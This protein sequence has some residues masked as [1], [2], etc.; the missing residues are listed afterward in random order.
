MTD[1]DRSCPLTTGAL[2]VRSSPEADVAAVEQDRR[3]EYDHLVP[4]F[5]ELARLPPEHAR[6]SLLRAALINGYR[7]VAKHIAGSFHRRGD[8]PEDIE[9]VATLGLILAVDRFDATRGADFLSFAVPTIT[10]EVRRYFRDRSTLIRVPRRLRELQALVHDA[11]AELGQRHGRAA[12]PSEIARLLDVDPE[13]VLECLQAAQTAY[14]SSLDEPA[15]DDAG[16][17]GFLRFGAA[18]GQVEA[19]FD[20]VEYREALGPLLAALPDRERHILLLRFYGEMTQTEIGHR[21]GLSQMHVSRLLT[22]TLSRLRRGLAAD[23][24]PPRAAR[25]DQPRAGRPPPQPVQRHR[26]ASNCMASASRSTS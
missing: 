14:C 5:D 20:L 17:D 18:L 13:V 8:S 25:D 16:P 4:L 26:S 19:E 24:A 22:R 15:R 12:R 3:T 9:Q 1:L 7:P 10:G 2:H 23:S 11:A 21:V 6:C